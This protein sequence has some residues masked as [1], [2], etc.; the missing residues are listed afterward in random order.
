MKYNF[1]FSILLLV[2]FSATLLAQD[3]EY[4]ITASVKK[5]PSGAM[6]YLQYKGVNGNVKDSVAIED[7]KFSFTGKIDEPRPAGIIIR[8]PNKKATT[9]HMTGFFIEPGNL[10]ITGKSMLFNANIT[11]SPATL[12]KKEF[13]KL[14]A[15]QQFP[16]TDRVAVT[17]TTRVVAVPAGSMPP[18]G[19]MSAGRGRPTSGTV[20]SQRTITDINELPFEMQSSIRAIRA[21]GKGKVMEF[22][23][24]HHNS[25][26]SMYA[27]NSLWNAKRITFIEYVSLTEILGQNL[28]Q[29]NGGKL[30]FPR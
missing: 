5:Y 26:V 27:L 2:C 9:Q 6:A 29:S 17:Q 12:E 8:E 13:D 20:V 30:M 3:K 19:T 7:G 28:K 18:S 21:E 10:I 23:K 15:G 16:Q 22:I 1:T 4:T 11:G 25:F 14:L 24:E